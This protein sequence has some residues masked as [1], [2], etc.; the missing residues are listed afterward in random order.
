MVSDVLLS[1]KLGD[2]RVNS[3][4]WLAIHTRGCAVVSAPSTSTPSSFA[5][6]IEP[7][8]EIGVDLRFGVVLQVAELQSECSQTEHVYAGGSSQPHVLTHERS[9][10]Y[11]GGGIVAGGE[12]A[13]VCV[14]RPMAESRHLARRDTAED[15]LP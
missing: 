4:L 9:Q 2:P 13:R 6:G 10:P 14:C 1:D 12:S 11:I 7:G 5:N 3:D 8:F 15:A